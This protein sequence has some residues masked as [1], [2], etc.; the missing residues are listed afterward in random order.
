MVAGGR[1]GRLRQARRPGRRTGRQN[2]RGRRER[3]ERAR[4]RPV[5]FRETFGDGRHPPAR[6]HCVRRPRRVATGAGVSRL[7]DPRRR[8]RRNRRATEPRRPRAGRRRR[9]SPVSTGEVAFAQSKDCAEAHEAPATRPIAMRP[10]A[11]N[12][13]RDGYDVLRTCTHPPRSL[14]SARAAGRTEPFLIARVFAPDKSGRVRNACHAIIRFCAA[15][16]SWAS[17]SGDCRRRSRLETKRSRSSPVWK[18]SPISGCATA[19]R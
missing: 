14:P 15:H 17:I 3:R 7:Q 1:D 16:L 13:W 8:A 5:G 6:R 12:T 4:A 10:L 19:A 2:G 11:A 9:R 18:R